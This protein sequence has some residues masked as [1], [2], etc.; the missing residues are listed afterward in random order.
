VI[1]FLSSN[2]FGYGLSGLGVANHPF[3][4]G[5]QSNL[6][7]QQLRRRLQMFRQHNPI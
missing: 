5:I 3:P 6:C 1:I 4:Y 2:L 7:R